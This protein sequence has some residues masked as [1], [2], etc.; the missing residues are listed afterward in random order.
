M[1][2]RNS[3]IEVDERVEIRS[4]DLDEDQ[5]TQVLKVTGRDVY[6]ECITLQ[7][8][9]ARYARRL[10]HTYSRF[11][12]VTELQ[13]SIERDPELREVIGGEDLPS[14]VEPVDLFQAVSGHIYGKASL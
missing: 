1:D 12:K 9:I 2:P 3:D 8:L 7:K 13:R 14:D 4:S 5:D 11:P 6:Q 10:A